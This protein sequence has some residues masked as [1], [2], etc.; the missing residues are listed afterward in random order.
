MK[1]LIDNGH[2]CDTR[3]KCS[4]DGRLR[5]YEYCRQIAR[6]IVETLKGYGYDV[7]LLT[8]E[9]KDIPIKER[10]ARANAICRKVGADN[11]VLVSIHVNAAGN[12]NKW[13][14]ATGWEAWTSKGNTSADR[15]AD[16]LYEAAESTLLPL[17]PKENPAKFIRTDYTDG[18]PDKEAG[19]YILRHTLCPAV[20]TENL[21]QDNKRDVDWLLSEAG[22]DAIVNL[23]VQGIIKNPC[24]R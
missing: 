19:F 17:F 6:R 21:F 2:G 24:I 16:S 8:P 14:S 20:L 15:L 18:D 13:M 5:E 4:P 1:I 3:G 9:E 12:G 23:H 7:A 10:C 11:V 22:K